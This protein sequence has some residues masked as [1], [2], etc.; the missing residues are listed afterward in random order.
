MRK[1]RRRKEEQ[2]A[3]EKKTTRLKCK[4]NILTYT[5]IHTNKHIWKS[6]Y[7]DQ[8]FTSNCKHM[9]HI[10]LFIGERNE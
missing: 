4:R 1:K 2:R 7:T 5:E 3:E 6:V 8:H 9:V 10:F